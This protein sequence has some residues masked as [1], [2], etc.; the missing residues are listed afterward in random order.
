MPLTKIGKEGITGISNSS[1]A[2][3]ITIDSSENIMV[4]HSS[5]NS[6]VADGGSGKRLG[7]FKQDLQELF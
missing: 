3:A 2:S 1:D 7:K 4:G 6:P 5:L